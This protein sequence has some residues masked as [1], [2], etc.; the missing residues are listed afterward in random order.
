MNDHDLDLIVDLIENR[1][2][3]S[4][5]KAALSRISSE[6]ELS[7][8]HAEQLAVRAALVAQP[9]PAMTIPES[10]S[11]RAKLATAL[12]LDGI[13]APVPIPRKRR[14]WWQPVAGIAAAAVV[15]TA[16]VVL[17]GNLSS[18]D[19]ATTATIAAS[20]AARSS[21]PSD[22]DD[23]VAESGVAEEEFATPDAAAL[24]RA[25]RAVVE[26]ASEDL[27]DVLDATV[28]E[29]SPEAVEDRL[30]ALGYTKSATVDPDVLADCVI[31]VVPQLP[32]ETKDI[33]VFGVDTSG[34]TPIALLG[35]VFDEG[36]RAAVSV[37]L[38]TCQIV[39]PSN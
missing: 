33:V 21:E 18:D 22:A 16:I 38:A 27:L 8:L 10:E 20:A 5:A 13:Q 32:A 17:P 39:T 35:L 24:R 36:I 25:P 15:V 26:L 7:S 23:G 9:L 31:R 14:A 34:P 3:A 2:S 30:N 4:D 12:R 1:L 19:A 29:S 6:P 28:G 11:L 37:D